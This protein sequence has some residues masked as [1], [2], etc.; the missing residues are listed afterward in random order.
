MAVTQGKT[1]LITGV[2][3]QDGSYL[4]E[5]LLGIGYEVHGLLRRSSYPNTARIEHLRSHPHLHLHYGDLSDSS[6]MVRLLLDTKPDEIYNLAA[7][8]HVMMSFGEPEYTGNTTGLGSLRLLEALRIL[9]LDARYYQASSS[10]MFGASPPPQ[11]ESTPFHPRSPYGVA[12]VY[13]H[14]ITRNYRESYGIF[15][16]NGMLFNHESPRR[17][18][19]FVTRKIT[20]AVAEISLGTRDSLALGN[21]D[22]R[23]DWGYAP[24]FV[25]AMWLMLQA[26]EP[27]DF[28]VGT[29]SSFSVQEFVQAAF[30]YRGLNW[31]DY[32]T[33]DQGLTRPAEVDDLV[34]DASLAHE[35]LGWKA[36]IAGLDLVPIMVDAD[37]RAIESNEPDLPQFLPQIGV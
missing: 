29:G 7:Q 25:Q 32:V 12:K 14:W 35:A 27:Q 23:R 28:V 30:E 18:E 21:L 22:A 36:K 11:N 34:G 1:A 16:V 33:F 6:R 26:D 20:K 17:G 31:V 8:S 19:N 24:E 37:I 3:G 4:A 9:K 15:A 2:T 13:A 10:E 5:F